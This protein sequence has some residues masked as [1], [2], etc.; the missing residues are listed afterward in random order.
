LH[1]ND[2]LSRTEGEQLL[3]AVLKFKIEVSVCLAKDLKNPLFLCQTVLFVCQIHLLL[4]SF[5]FLFFSLLLEINPF[6]IQYP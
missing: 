3:R 5:S 2:R 1:E 6:F 4:F